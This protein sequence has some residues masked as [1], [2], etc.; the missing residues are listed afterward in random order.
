M[1][2]MIGQVCLIILRERPDVVISTGAAPGA[3]ALRI[4]KWLGAKTVWI[5]SIANVEKI[6]MSGSK[7]GKFSD[8][9]LTQWEHLTNDHG[10]SFRG[11]HL[12]FVT[13]G[14]QMPFRRLIIAM[15]EWAIK[16]NVDIDVFAQIGDTD[17]R[18]KNMSFTRS[19]SPKEFT[20]KLERQR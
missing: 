8:L 11:G 18:P 10:P 12:I 19:M 20:E 14:S 7:V 2:K 6:S 15:D 5:D 9:W 16:R 4:G 3:V 13:V 17:Y 1:I